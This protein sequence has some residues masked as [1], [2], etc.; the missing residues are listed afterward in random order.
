MAAFADQIWL[1]RIHRHQQP[2]ADRW[3][4]PFLFGSVRAPKSCKLPWFYFV[5]TLKE[6]DVVL[7]LS[8]VV[9]GV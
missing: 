4:G 2:A 3:L 7:L 1:H 9:L 8:M 5:W 6:T